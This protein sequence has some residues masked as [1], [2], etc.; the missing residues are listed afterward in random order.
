MKLGAHVSVSGGVHNAPEN[1]RTIG[2][3]CFQLFTKNQN[4]WR[5]RTFT[6]PEVDKYQEA[7]Q[8]FAYTSSATVSHAS[9]LINLCATDS[10]KLHKSR[11]AFSEE[12][13]RCAS[14]SIPYLVFH[15]GSHLDATP[16]QGLEAI[17]ESLRI[18]IAQ[19]PEATVRLLL[20]TTAGQGTNLGYRFD[21]LATIVEMVEKPD[22]LGICLDTCHVFAAG[23]DLK[24]RYE[25]VMEEFDQQIGLDKLHLLHLNDSLKPLGSRVDRHARIGAG[26]IGPQAFEQL[27]NDGRIEDK[28]MILEVPGGDDGY[29]EDLALLRQFRAKVGG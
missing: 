29:R 25:E 28:M 15:P 13:K 12:I 2:A 19:T 11:H 1:A 4:Q 17:A 5:E 27:M 3:D 24:H 14:L 20:E 18:A 6:H 22:Q 21:Q 16:E 26:M 8:N 7:L 9:Y 10:E 23:Y